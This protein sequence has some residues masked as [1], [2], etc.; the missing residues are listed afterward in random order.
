MSILTIKPKILPGLEPDFL[1]AAL[2]NRAFRA[3]IEKNG[4]G[5][6]LAVCLVQKNGS[7]HTFRT[8]I[9]PQ[10]QI[11]TP[12]NFLYVERLVKTLLWQVGGWK[13]IIGGPEYIGRYIAECYSD[14]GIRK[15]DFHF[16][17][18]VY[19]RQLEIK[20]TDYE[21]V[22]EADE[23]SQPIGRHL[24][25]CRVGFDAGGSDRKASAVVDGEVVYSEEV[26]WHP[27]TSA[28]PEYHY[29]EILS[30]I[31]TAA[32]KMPRLDAIGV[33]SAGIY[34]DNRVMAASLFRKVPDDLFEKRIKNIYL[35]IA[36]EMG[37]VPVIVANDGDVTALAGAM[38]LDDVC[39]LGIAMGT[40]E[41]GGYVDEKGNITGWLN[42]LAF[43]PVD[44]NLQASIDEWSGDYGC[45]AQYFS[46]D[47]IIRL[48]PSA[49]IELDGRLTPAEKLKYVQQ[50][51]SGG[52]KGAKLI[53]ETIGVY[54]GYG[55]AY[56]AELYNIRHVLLLGRVTSGEGGNIILRFA[57]EVLA[58]DFP[59]LA[60]R[61]HLHLPDESSRRIGQ[62][63]AA[64]SLPE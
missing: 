53:Y 10:S 23:V 11:N 49:G 22:P 46:Q 9:L 37:P 28:D 14:Q 5:V 33:S 64:A 39:V 20:I 42:E 1:P 3:A 58:A 4:P 8:E 61:I 26:I 56:Y 54:L 60:E 50:L 12:D 31:R 57:R 52:H 51:M 19:E 43:I 59:D 47:A 17:S 29:R 30:A 7:H 25:G 6:P 35:D 62:S 24:N 16:M 40:S 32:A 55:L 18:K 36:A 27:K 21:R 34:I 48:A 44:Y 15:F 38:D 45:G 63:V 13:I 41:A 2:F